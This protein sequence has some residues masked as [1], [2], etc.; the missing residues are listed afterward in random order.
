M[1][2]EE[3]GR[4]T[5][6]NARDVITLMAIYVAIYYFNARRLLFWIREFDKEYFQSLGFVGGVGMR[7]SVAIGKILF[8][9]SLPKPDYPPGFKFRLKFTRFILFFSPGVAVVMIFLAA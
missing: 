6:M 1:K 8:D 3:E 2:T 5:A 4:K 7:N 9:R